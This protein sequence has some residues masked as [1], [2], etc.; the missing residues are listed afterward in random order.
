MTFFNKKEEVLQIELTQYGKYL[1]SLGKWAPAYYAFYDDNILYDGDCAGISEI[2]N[3]IEPR[4]QENTPQLKPQHTFLGRE[5]DFLKSYYKLNTNLT[6]KHASTSE[7]DRIKME[8]PKAREYSLQE[9]LG[10]TDNLSQKAPRW[11]VEFLEGEVESCEHFLTSSFQTLRIPQ[12]NCAIT[13]TTSVK[14][15]SSMS[16]TSLES[17]YPEML[18]V[19]ISSD[20]YSDGSY[21]AAQTDPFILWVKEENGLFEKEN[22]DIE[23]YKS[24][25][26]GYEPLFFQKKAP[27]VRDD[28][29]VFEEDPEITLDETYV[30]YYFNIYTDSQISKGELCKAIT[31]LKAQNRYLDL[32]IEC[33]DD[34]TMTTLSPYIDA[35]PSPSECGDT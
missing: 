12:V 1:L 20:I 7:L 26:H 34:G 25:S 32:E 4:I 11:K 24:A 27:Q 30:G 31:Q 21:I 9:P 17:S 18:P 5:T 28:L 35:A 14:N 19:D 2:Q 10:T 3:D 29:L 16:P 13:Y 23:V 22:F 15:I 6:P 33:P 8:S